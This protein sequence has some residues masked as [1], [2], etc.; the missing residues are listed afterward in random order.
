MKQKDYRSLKKA[1]ARK[2]SRW[3]AIIFS[4]LTLTALLFFTTQAFAEESKP[5]QTAEYNVYAGGIH[6]LEVNMVNDLQSQERYEVNMT[7]ETHGILGKLAPW[8]GSFS[9]SGWKGDIYKP[10]QHQSVAT[11]R[12]E[13]ETKTYRY[14]KDGSFE[15]YKVIEEGKDKT[16]KESRLRIHTANT[17]D[18]LTAAMNTMRDISAGQSCD[19]TT[20]IFDGK[21]RFKL[22]FKKKQDVMRCWNHPVT[23]S[24]VA[25]PLNAQ[26]SSNRSLEN[27]MRNPVA[28]HPF[29]SKAVKKAVCQRS[30]LLLWKRG[31]SRNPCESPREN[32]LWNTLSCISPIITP[33]IIKSSSSH[34][35]LS[36]SSNVIVCKKL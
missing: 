34:V 11:W 35:N 16:P 31:K 25:P 13:E 8:S 2:L 3:P 36:A 12:G 22:H 15:S 21:R 28:G 29:K 4:L 24:M 6:A 17:T 1:Q 7:A 26:R 20:E 33:A 19:S 30:G 18:I 9:T 27:G 5:T 23:I 10:E 14:K 32:G